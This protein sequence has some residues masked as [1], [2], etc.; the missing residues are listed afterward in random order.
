MST[1][2]QWS[3]GQKVLCI[4][5]SFPRYSADWYNALRIAGNIYT[6]R[7]M[8]IG[9]E[10]ITGMYD[11][12]LLLEEISSPRKADGTEAGF[13]HTRF[14]P[15]LEADAGHTSAAEKHELAE[16]VSPSPCRAFG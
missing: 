8:Q 4:D 12:G 7:A 5:D 16:D 3:I 1:H 6:I 15:W 2:H 14:V 11:L 13:F 10:P 9:S